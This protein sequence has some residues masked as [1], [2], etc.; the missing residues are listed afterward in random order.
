[1]IKYSVIIPLYN[2]ESTINRCLDS[3]ILQNEKN[4]EIVIVNDGSLDNS[5]SICEDYSKKY[6]YIRIISK[7]NGGPG[8]ARNVGIKAAKGKYL[9]FV[10]D[11]DYINDNFFK[12]MNKY[13][14]EDIDMLK[15][16]VKYHGNRIDGN[17][18]NTDKFN[19]TSGL[20]FLENMVKQ[21]K[22]FATPW[23]YVY[24]REL[25]IDNN[26]FFS[27]NHI[28]EDYGLIPCLIIKSNYIKGI[29]YVGYNY[30]YREGSLST[31]QDYKEVV[32]RAFDM[33][34]QYDF[35]YNFATKNIK[36]KRIKNDFLDYIKINLLRKQTKLK[37][38]E[39]VLFNNELIKREVI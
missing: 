31:N 4:I 27:E 18:F 9:V 5:L 28:H 25:F 22:I 35:L 12:T 11:D 10:D 38:E 19:K 6:D 14:S 37:G 21:N 32:R 23:M 39:L 13:L 15:F 26:L 30:V 7:K 34:Y 24:R 20:K 17:V 36:E 3:I 33:I 8:S 29:D 2:S 16:N 1:M